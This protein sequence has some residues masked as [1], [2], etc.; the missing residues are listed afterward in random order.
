M[1]PSHG[2]GHQGASRHRWGTGAGTHPRLGLDVLPQQ[3]LLVEGVPGL[4]R[5]GVD[6]AFVDLL[7]DGADQQEEGLSDCLLGKGKNTSKQTGPAG[8]NSFQQC[9]GTGSART[10]EVPLPFGEQDCPP[11]WR[12]EPSAPS[13]ISPRL[14]PSFQTCGNMT[15]Q[16]GKRTQQPTTAA[17]ALR[18]GRTGTASV[19]TAQP[20]PSARAAGLT[21]AGRASSAASRAEHAGAAQQG[22]A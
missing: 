17:G 1:W 3:P 20:A 21:P 6:G 22:G 5:D 15:A 12:C 10:L 14:L 9:G 19:N 2:H 18:G 7:F 16:T 13:S 11:P 8:G 4:P